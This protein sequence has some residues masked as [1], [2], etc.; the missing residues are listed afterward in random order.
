MLTGRMPFEDVSTKRLRQKIVSG[1]YP[2]LEGP[3]MIGDLIARMLE[4]DEDKRIECEGIIDHAGFRGGLPDGYEPPKPF[5]IIDLK[6]RLALA[7]EKG[8]CSI[9]SWVVDELPWPLRDEESSLE[10]VFSDGGGGSME[11]TLRI[12]GAAQD[13][14]AIMRE[15]Q[16]LL[17]KIGFDWLHP[18][19]FTLISRRPSDGLSMAFEL[20][21][22]EW[23]TVE[24]RVTL[25]Q[26]SA[27]GFDFIFIE[28]GRAMNMIGRKV[29]W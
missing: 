21:I 7:E 3:E 17:P 13:G 6:K 29:I 12:E 20:E 27:V 28:F 15:L 11:Q 14:E 26:G 4:V 22:V 25:L 16:L 10:A 23:G 24:M 2:V 1:E 18:T 5:M 8:E 19:E 9:E